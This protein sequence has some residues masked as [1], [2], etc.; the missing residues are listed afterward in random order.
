[1]VLVA[2]PDER[3]EI[4]ILADG[5]IAVEVFRSD[6]AVSSGETARKAVAGLLTTE[7]GCHQPSG[8][9]C[10]RPARNAPAPSMHPAQVSPAPLTTGPNCGR[11]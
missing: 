4:E 1:M 7:G 5:G 9:E 10:R 3:W 6:G 11:C 8:G 2:V